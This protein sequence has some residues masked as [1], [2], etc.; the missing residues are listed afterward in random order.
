M[1]T[2][3]KLFF[4]CLMLSMSACNN[5][6]KKVETGSKNPATGTKTDE[7]T[8][9]SDGDT[10]DNDAEKES[11]SDTDAEE[12]KDKDADDSDSKDAT[13]KPGIAGLLPK[14]LPLIKSIMSGGMPDMGSIMSIFADLIGGGGGLSGGGLDE[15]YSSSGLLKFDD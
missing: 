12:G 4:L 11:D 15:Q 13:G 2:H 3:L 6:K 10:A 8:K 14:I 5:T 7:K 9:D 1:S